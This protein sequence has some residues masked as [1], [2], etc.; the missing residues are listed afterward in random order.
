MTRALLNALPE[1]MLF[2][3]FL[4]VPVCL[5]L[6]GTWCIRKFLPGWKRASAQETVGT[7]VGLVS[8]FF[9]LV[10]AFAIVNLYQRYEDASYR[11]NATAASLT[12]LTH[13]AAAFPAPEQQRID[14]AVGAY[15][16]RLTSV[17]FPGLRKGT[18]P[19]GTD[20]GLGRLYQVLE[21]YHPATPTE[22]SFY[23][24]SIAELG[25][26][27]S[28]EQQ[29]VSDGTSSLPAAFLALLAVT[30]ILT[31]AA[32]LLLSAESPTFESALTASIAAAIG[33]GWLTV[34]I[35]EFPFSGSVSV[36]TA[37][38]THGYLH[39]LVVMPH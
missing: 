39:H 18:L 20:P 25:T 1:W 14:E 9:A 6:A 2:I 37:A 8:T 22:V 27:L 21:S 13:D 15:A 7:V 12:V 33:I 35:L 29:F 36:S 3:L 24:A 32:S 19:Q 5:A 30:A 26:L 17:V 10:L 31:L 38:F 16:A 23:D 4:L 34:A 11:V 28:N